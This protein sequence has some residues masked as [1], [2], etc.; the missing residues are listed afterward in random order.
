MS[1]NTER[2]EYAKLIKPLRD[3]DNSTPGPVS[4]SADQKDE[5]IEVHGGDQK[6][7]IN[8]K[9]DDE[10]NNNNIDQID[11]IGVSSVSRKP[12]FSQHLKADDESNNDPI[13]VS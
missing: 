2:K 11:P 1:T 7:H 6:F 10:S 4:I 13:A 8:Q 12:G 9:A 3:S 5:K